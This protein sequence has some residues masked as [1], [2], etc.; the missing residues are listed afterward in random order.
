MAKKTRKE[1][2]TAARDLLC[3]G[4]SATLEEIKKAYREQAKKHHPDT[5]QTKSGNDVEMH[6]LTDAYQTLLDYCAGYRFP[7]ALD[8]LETEDDEDWWMNRFGNDPL[9]GKG[10][11]KD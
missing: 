11:G 3:L 4:E 5:A 9:W 6:A 1:K 7:L 8:E 10:K 2:I